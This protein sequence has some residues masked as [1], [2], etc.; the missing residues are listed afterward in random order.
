VR[1]PLE[2]ERR[3]PD[4]ILIIENDPGVRRDLASALVDAGFI[5]AAVPDYSTKLSELSHYKADLVIID[6]MLPSVDGIEACQHIRSTYDIPVV[7]LGEDYS[8]EAWEK[9]LQADA[10]LYE[11]KPF[12]Y[13]ILVA[14]MKA[15]LRRYKDRP[16]TYNQESYPSRAG[17]EESMANEIKNYTGKGNVQ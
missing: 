15:M 8:D 3:M 11:A 17:K 16:Q 1:L 2:V 13:R 9:A 6:A 5:I 10:S 14:R 4:S 7:L 12:S